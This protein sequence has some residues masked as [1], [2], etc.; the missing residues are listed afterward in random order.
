[1]NEDD[2]RLMML[3]FSE[4]HRHLSETRQKIQQ[5]TQHTIGLLCVI[6]GWVILSDV[7]SNNDLLL[8]LTAVIVII[9][10]FSIATLFRFNGNYRREAQVINRL[11]Q[12]FHL[13]EVGKYLEDQSIYPDQW[14]VFGNESR[15]KGLKFYILCIV[16]MGI[17]AVVAVLDPF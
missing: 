15:V 12:H 10:V 7:N 16:A 6:A 2:D 8:T 13:F 11:N 9:S 4:H 17:A 3:L 14:K 1:M 5:L